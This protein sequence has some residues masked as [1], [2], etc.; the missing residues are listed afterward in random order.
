MHDRNT[1]HKKRLLNLR[2]GNVLKAY[3]LERVFG[4]FMDIL[5]DLLEISFVRYG[6][7]DVLEMSFIRYGCFKDVSEIFFGNFNF[8]TYLNILCILHISFFV[9]FH[10]VCKLFTKKVKTPER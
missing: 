8:G 3:V 6:C 9:I 1:I 5:K 7:K 10:N 4:T 2:Y